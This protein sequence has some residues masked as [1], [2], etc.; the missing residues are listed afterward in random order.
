[1]KEQKKNINRR[2]KTSLEGQ[3]IAVQ[4]VKLALIRSS[5]RILIENHLSWLKF[6]HFFS[7]RPNERRDSPHTIKHVIIASSHSPIR[8][9]FIIFLTY[10]TRQ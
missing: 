10:L 3:A 4:R 8:S 7:V 1:M 5:F 6:S 9:P 2:N